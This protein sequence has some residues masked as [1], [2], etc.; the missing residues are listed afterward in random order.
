M[1]EIEVVLHGKVQEVG[2]RAFIK[3]RADERNLDGFVENMEDG[4]VEVLAQGKEEDLTLFIEE[5]KG[6][7]YFSRV[8][9][10]EITWHDEPQDPITGF[11]IVQ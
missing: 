4:S 7:P 1:K 2:M 5:I 6:G 8:D 9:S 11:S 3:K 10:A